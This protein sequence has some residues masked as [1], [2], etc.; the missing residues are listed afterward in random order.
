MR[1]PLLL[2][3]LLVAIGLGGCKKDAPTACGANSYPATVLRGRNG[4]DPNGYLLQL[5][6]GAAYPTDSLP[7]S[8]Q[9][10]GLKVCLAYSLYEDPRFC[11]CCGG[12]RLTIRRIQRQ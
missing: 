4:C 7:G 8:F 1:V 5:D 3:L 9:Q 10:S 2:I 6:G 12:T 11:A